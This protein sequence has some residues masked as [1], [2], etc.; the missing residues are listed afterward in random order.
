MIRPATIIT[1]R[2]T[3]DV[4]GVRLNA[5][6]GKRIQFARDVPHAVGDVVGLPRLIAKA[7]IQAGVARLEGL[8]NF[9]E[10]SHRGG[11]L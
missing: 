8:E 1:V 9:E 7:L 10:T 4:T 11:R 3:G 2:I 5:G 6:R